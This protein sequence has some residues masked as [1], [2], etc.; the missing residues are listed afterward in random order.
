MKES[1]ATTAIAKAYTH[2]D[3][4]KVIGY[5]ELMNAKDSMLNKIENLEERKKAAM[6]LAGLQ[7]IP[8]SSEFKELVVY[9]LN[10]FQHHNKYSLLRT[11]EEML[12]EALA[13]MSQTLDSQDE[14]T[15]LKNWKLKGD[16]DV[17]CERLIVGIEQL[18]RDIYGE[19]VDV[20]KEQMKM[21]LSPEQRLRAKKNGV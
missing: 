18:Y 9:Y 15:R 14:D 20:A 5:I 17:L 2:P 19:L 7:T 4:E 3:K 10:Y 11:R 16:L 1:F 13:D 8:D 12:A 6:T 21:G